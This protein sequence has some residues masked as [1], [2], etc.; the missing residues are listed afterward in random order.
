M[1]RARRLGHRIDRLSATN[2][3]AVEPGAIRG[4]TERASVLQRKERSAEV[5]WAVTHTVYEQGK[6]KKVGLFAGKDWWRNEGGEL[7]QGDKISVD[8]EDVFQS[9]R[10]ANQEEESRR[11]EDRAGER[12]HKWVRLIETEDGK[13]PEREGKAPFV[14]EETIRYKKGEKQEIGVDKAESFAALAKATDLSSISKA[15]KERNKKRRRSLGPWEVKE[16]LR[17]EYDADSS[18]LWDQIDEGVDV[19]KWIGE[20]GSHDHLQQGEKQKKYEQRFYYAYYGQDKK[21]PIAQMT[22]EQRDSKDIDSRVPRGQHWYLRWLVGHPDKGGGGSALVQQAIQDT[23]GKPIYVESSP[24]GVSFY[25]G[26]GFKLIDKEGS[27]KDGQPW[28]YYSPL[29]VYGR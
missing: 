8:D 21:K 26:K 22:L 28:G 3:A 14:R 9:R 20:S 29:M 27:K 24:S 19:S 2:H 11:K 15:W 4:D 5:T 17:T 7:N 1:A 23:E 12:F 16:E 25:T 18:P 13:V 6:D 10:G